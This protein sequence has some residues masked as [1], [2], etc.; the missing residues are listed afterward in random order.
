MVEAVQLLTL[1]LVRQLRRNHR[2]AFRLALAL[3]RCPRRPTKLH[4]P[5]AEAASFPL[6]KP[7][8]R[9][10]LC[11]LLDVYNEALYTAGW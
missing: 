8:S 11:E 5:A 7:A 6:S 2:S 3:P 1:H 9:Q 4:L 10:H